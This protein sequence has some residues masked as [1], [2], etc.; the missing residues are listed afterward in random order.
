[1]NPVMIL[2][3]YMYIVCHWRHVLA[4]RHSCHRASYMCML[5]RHKYL[6]VIV[7]HLKRLFYPFIVA[8]ESSSLRII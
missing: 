4:R 5:R 7:A 1:M 8:S 6:R 2:G 3:L